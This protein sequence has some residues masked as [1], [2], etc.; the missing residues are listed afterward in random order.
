MS[1]QVI[2]EDPTTHCSLV[3][4]LVIVDVDCNVSC[5]SDEVPEMN[6][7]A[8]FQVLDWLAK[9]RKVGADMKDVTMQTELATSVAAALIV[10]WRWRCTQSPA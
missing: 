7:P 2:L 6:S 9:A 4:S 8:A 3:M 5:G 10:R 1:C